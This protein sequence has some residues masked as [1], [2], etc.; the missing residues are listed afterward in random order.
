MSLERKN[1]FYEGKE[2]ENVAPVDEEYH[3]DDEGV[4]VSQTDKEGKFTYVNKRFRDV[5][6]YSYD[7][8]VGN[9]YSIIRHPDMP[10]AAFA[11]MWETIESGQVFN[12]IIKNLRKDGRY[13]WVNLEIL[14]IKDEDGDIT[15][16]ISV[17][18]PASRKDIEENEKIYK[19]MLESEREGAL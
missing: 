9:S 13:Y 12:G 11:K 10:D 15:G 1:I 4:L 2:M 14:P 18:R 19:K 17:A 16:Y 8:L 5:S 6:G 7:E 3:F